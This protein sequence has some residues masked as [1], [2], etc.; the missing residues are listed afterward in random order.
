MAVNSLNRNKL[1]EAKKKKAQEFKEQLKKFK[2]QPSSSFRS[3]EEKKDNVLDLYTKMSP[4]QKAALEKELEKE[5][6]EREKNGQI[7]L[8]DDFDWGD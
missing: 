6:E 4:S 2:E 7:T 3:E 1:E 8:F 5:K